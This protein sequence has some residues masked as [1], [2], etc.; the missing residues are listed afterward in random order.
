MR[1][2]VCAR[3]RRGGWRGGCR[4][5]SFVEALAGSDPAW[6]LPWLVPRGRLPFLHSL[7]ISVPRR[8]HFLRWP[9]VLRRA[10]LRVRAAACR[11]A[12][13][14]L[15]GPRAGG[16]KRRSA[17]VGARRRE[18]GRAEQERACCPL[19]LALLAAWSAALLPEAAAAP[20]PA[21][22]CPLA[23]P[24]SPS[25]CDP[26]GGGGSAGKPRAVG[27]EESAGSARRG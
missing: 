16:G 9:T 1:V 6:R 20:R 23:V 15:S 24:G 12:A 10:S 17:D 13:S 8:P 3:V 14:R 2:R 18:G 22:P 4:R 7:Y 11:V 5:G 21:P 19:Q 27:G 25:C 26:R